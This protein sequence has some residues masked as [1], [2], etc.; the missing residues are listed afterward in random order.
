MAHQLSAVAVQADAAQAVVVVLASLASHD[1]SIAA[2]NVIQIGQLASSR[3]FCKRWPHPNRP[4]L[5]DRF[6]RNAA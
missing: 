1:A 2:S 3:S 6:G 4:R 5:T